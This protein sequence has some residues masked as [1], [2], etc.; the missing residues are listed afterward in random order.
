MVED[1]TLDQLAEIYKCLSDKTRLKIIFVLLTGEKNVTTIS[2]E[3]DMGQSATSHQ[4]R[5]LK[6]LKLVKSRKEGRS[7]LYSLDDDHVVSLLTEGMD[8]V[9]HTI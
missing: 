1:K 4:L 5:K 2:E 6:D 3:I 9:S 8:H 7:V